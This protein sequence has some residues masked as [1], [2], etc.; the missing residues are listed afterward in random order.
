MQINQANQKSNYEYFT[1]NVQLAKK[2][3]LSEAVFLSALI[4][5]H[6]YYKSQNKLRDGMFYF[7]IN[8]IFDHTGINPRKQASII[9]KLK[10][11]H[12]LTT[13]LKGIPAR[14]F[15]KLNWEGIMNLNTESEITKKAEQVKL[16][17]KTIYNK[18]ENINIIIKKNISKD[19]YSVSDKT[20]DNNSGISKRLIGRKLKRVLPKPLIKPKKQIINKSSQWITLWNN[21]PNTPKHKNINTKV[22]QQTKDLLDKIIQG[23]FKNKDVEIFLQD[24]KIKYDFNQK[25]SAGQV[26]KILIELAK[27]FDSATNPNHKM[28]PRSLKTLIFNSF[29]KNGFLSWFFIAAT[30]GI[31]YRKPIENPYPEQ[32]SKIENQFFRRKL[33]FLEQQLLT[34]KVIAIKE[35]QVE[36]FQWNMEN[37]HWNIHP[38]IWPELQSTDN[39]MDKYLEFLNN[40]Y[41]KYMPRVANIGVG[42]ASWQVFIRQL[43]DHWG[44][45][46]QVYRT[47]F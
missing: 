23:K 18:K 47:K 42:V 17:S 16:K 4:S 32:T 12:V 8:S 26:R 15:F 25:L 10:S 9:K 20:L 30:T 41:K 11:L 2:Y 36:I 39:F 28:V 1:G 5:K 44:H 6:N 46:K 31:N 43:S 33:S 7:T 13:K 27:L 38:G 24:K 34:Q 22:Y 29:S 19:I 3:G 35:Y 14:T 37:N 21:L 40:Y 45:E